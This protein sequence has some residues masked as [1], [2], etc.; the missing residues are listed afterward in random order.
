VS[1]GLGKKEER[2]KM[3]AEFHQ[4]WRGEELK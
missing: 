4:V 1:E 3:L 2:E